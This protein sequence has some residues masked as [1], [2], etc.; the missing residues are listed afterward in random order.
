MATAPIHVI[1][2]YQ[3]HKA[4]LVLSTKQ[5]KKRTMVAQLEEVHDNPLS[6]FYG[7]KLMKYTKG[8]IVSLIFCKNCNV[9]RQAK[10]IVKAISI[11]SDVK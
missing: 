8:K 7:E 5:S 9:T 6:S 3:Y 1:E 11:N 10:S 2:K 4:L